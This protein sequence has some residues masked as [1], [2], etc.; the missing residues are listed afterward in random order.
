MD[1]AISVSILAF[2]MGGARATGIGL[3]FMIVLRLIISA[4]AIKCSTHMPMNG[5][6]C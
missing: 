5:R 6:Y 1:H 3:M 2:A 4:V